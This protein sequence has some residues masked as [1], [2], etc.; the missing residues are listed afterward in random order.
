MKHELLYPFALA[1]VLHE[2]YLWTCAWLVA[3]LFRDV[4]APPITMLQ[5]VW[6]IRGSSSNLQNIKSKIVP[7]YSSKTY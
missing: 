2:R 5:K 4:S 7:W 1:S 6:R 3:L